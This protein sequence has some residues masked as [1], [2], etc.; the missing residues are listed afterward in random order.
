[1]TRKYAAWIIALAFAATGACA[2][3]PAPEAFPQ[4]VADA[5]AQRIAA[6]DAAGTA[7]F[8]TVDAVLMPPDAE[9]LAGRASIQEFFERTNAEGSPTV[10][11]ATVETFVFGDHAWRQG[12]FRIDGPG[13]D[14]PTNGKFVEL[15]KKVD[16]AWLIHRDIWHANAPRPAAEAEPTDAASDEP[17]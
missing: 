10:E 15:W 5:F 13:E 12:S 7:T 17:A 2:R 9:P 16:G 4:D 8:Y 6:Q 3:S 14:A 11:L 1:M